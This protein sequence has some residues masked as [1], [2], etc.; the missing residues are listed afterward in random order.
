M[1]LIYWYLVQLNIAHLKKKFAT[2]IQMCLLKFIQMIV[3]PI[4]HSLLS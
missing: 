1:N 2:Y 4:M 3:H